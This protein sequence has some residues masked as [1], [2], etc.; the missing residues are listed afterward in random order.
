[1]RSSARLAAVVAAGYWF[2]A[3]SAVLRPL[4]TALDIAYRG[5]TRDAV[6]LTFD[7]GPHLQG[8]P[9]VLD[10]LERYNARATFFL[11]GE[12]VLRYP[13]LAAEIVAAGH[14][15]GLHCHRHRLLLR[16]APWTLEDD[17]RR[18]E[19]AIVDAVGREIR[20]YRPPYGILTLPAI[21]SARSR[22]WHTILWTRQG[23]DWSHRATVTSI[24]GRLTEELA[25]RDI[26]LL[27]DADHYSAPE[28]WKRTVGALP[29]VL[30][31][32]AARGLAA[33]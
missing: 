3:T 22:G 8:T 11:V 31:A 6:S 26:L 29:I 1:M 20:L 25:G 32:M 24:A 27:H 13:T 21:L 9:A 12:Q 5:H 16:L 28:S 30:E 14:Q 17:L 33:A 23:R 4:G 2:P 15:V 7:D 10:T 19:A 18:A